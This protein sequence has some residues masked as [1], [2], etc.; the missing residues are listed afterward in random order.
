MQ[1]PCRTDGQ[2]EATQTTPIWICRDGFTPTRRSSP[3]LQGYSE[4]LPEEAVDQRGRLKR[5]RPEP[6]YVQENSED[7]RSNVRSQPHHRCRSQREICKSQQQ[8]PPPT[9][10]NANAPSPL[11]CPRCQRTFRAPIGLVEHLRT[12]CS[13]QTAPNVASPLTSHTPPTPPTNIDHPPE[14]ALPSSP[15]S[16]TASTSAAEASTMPINITHSPDTPTNTNTITVSTGYENLAYTCP[17]CDRTFTLHIGLVGHL[18]TRRTETGVPV[19]GAPT[20]TRRIRL[21][22]PHCPRTFIGRMDLLGHMRI[23]DNPR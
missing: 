13:I 22:C 10:R 11:T 5:P 16:P 20:Y 9:L 6:T 14:P 4:N 2:R 21:S 18:L 7:R 8:Q 15:S 23:H 19:P 1:R 17:H 12:N 3:A